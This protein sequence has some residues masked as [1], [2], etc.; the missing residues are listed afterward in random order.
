MR[1]LRTLAKLHLSSLGGVHLGH[2]GD[3]T[4]DGDFAALAEQTFVV[5]SHQPV[6]LVKVYTGRHH[7]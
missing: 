6:L 5:Q 3:V 2:I 7:P 4:L 1:Y